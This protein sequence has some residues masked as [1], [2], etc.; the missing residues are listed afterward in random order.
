MVSE[1][2]YQ[3][4][5]RT[6]EALRDL[7][8]AAIRGVASAVT[9]GNATSYRTM[10]GLWSFLT[11]NAFTYTVGALT[12]TII[13][14]YIQSAWDNGAKDLD[15]MMVGKGAKDEIDNM[16]DSYRKVQQGTPGS[17]TVERIVETFETS[18]GVLEIMLSRWMRPNSLIIFSSRRIKVL[19]LKGRSFQYQDIAKT[20]DSMKGMIVGEYTEEVLNQEG[21]AK[22]W[23]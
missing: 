13:A 3:K 21:M 5:S 2:D 8:R 19:P 14:S 15:I 6:R 18:Y 1:L 17:R 16:L 4:V 9:L 23:G 22:A 12:S 11:T 7:E 20:G 10:N